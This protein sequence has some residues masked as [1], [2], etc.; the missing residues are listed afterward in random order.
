MKKIIA[1]AALGLLM[2]TTTVMAH[3]IIVFAW[4]EQGRIHIEGS[5]G[6][7]RP[8]KNCVIQ[9]KNTNGA[10]VHQGL[11][12]TQGL[13]S[14]D[15]PDQVESLTVE[16]NAGSGHSGHWT[17]PENELVHPPTPETLEEKMAQKQSLKK[18][19]S[20]VKILAGIAVIFGLAF[21]AAWVKKRKRD[22]HN[23]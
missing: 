5:F 13:Y 15:L 8:A 21:V 1:L 22:A 19:P 14:F 4:V 7:N 18:A 6:S 23:A 20:L 3:K 16:L 12:D 9:V 2:S 11:T 10:L 17:I